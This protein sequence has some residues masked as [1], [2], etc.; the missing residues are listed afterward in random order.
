MPLRKRKE[1]G[2]TLEEAPDGI[3]LV[4][5]GDWTP[6]AAAAL[7]DGQADGLVLNYARGFRERDLSFLRGL[8][9]RRLQLLA[10]TIKNLSPVHDL[11]ASLLAL[12]VECDPRA[13]I[14][15]DRLPLLRRLSAT[16]SQVRSTLRYVQRLEDL[17]LLAY[18][19]GDLTPLT[20]V[21]SLASVV[22]K[23]RPAVQTLSGIEDLASLRQFS[24]HA[25]QRLDDITALGRTDRVMLTTLEL[26]ACKQVTDLT[27]T[28]ACRSLRH[29]DLGD[30]GEIPTVKPLGAL[31]EL[32]GL[33]L[34]GST[35]VLDGDLTPIAGLPRL[36][37]FRM[38]NRPA[39]TP[40]VRA[41][42]EAI[43]R[44]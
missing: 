2:F 18:D 37:D 42:Q 28:T 43:T 15:L 5:T 3:D 33:Y 36:S 40:P 4:V 12:A 23:D 25:A 9:V 19:E 17:F 21:P 38:Q 7:R 27:P 14:E 10:R 1:T 24:A 8:P 41:I 26:P 31:V 30:G 44:R 32:E 22:L 34:Y 29:L 16:W 11:G 39:Y 20:T 13:E 35:H 6:R